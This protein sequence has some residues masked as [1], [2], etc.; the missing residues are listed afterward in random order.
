MTE[1]A[2]LASLSQLEMVQELNEGN[3]ARGNTITITAF[4]EL[5]I[6]PRRHTLVPPQLPV[7]VQR[8]TSLEIGLYNL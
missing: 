7:F 6:L 1:A 3:T 8:P 4:L 5:L 2:K